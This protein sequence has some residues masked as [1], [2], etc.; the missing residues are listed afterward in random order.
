MGRVA[1]TGIG[2]ICA[3]GR[4]VSEF[5]RALREGRPAIAPIEGP[6]ISRLRF[7]NGAQLRGYS[8]SPHFGDR[9]ADFLDRFAQFAV[10]AARE[11]AADAN[12][13]WT[14]E[15]KADSAVVTGT[16]VGGQNTQDLAFQA[17]YAQRTG[18]VNPLSIPKV[19][20]NAGASQISMDFGITG[21][22]YTFSTACS[23]AGHAIGHAF[24]MIKH[25]EVSMAITGGSEAPFSWGILKGWEA[26]RVVST[27]TCRPFSKGRTG[28]ILGEGAAMFVLEP[29][30]A[31]RARGARI[32]AEIT[33]FG[34]SSDATHITCP[35]P[36]GASRAMHAALREA[37]V[38]PE[39][40]GYINAH[41][42]GTIANDVCEAT[43]IRAV[44]GE[45]ASRIAVSSTKSLHGHALGAAAALEAA[46]TILALRDGQLPPT[47]NFL[48]P[49]PDCDLD[50]IANEARALQVE[51]AIS[52]SFAFGGM[53]AVL[54]FRTAL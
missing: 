7:T 22:S 51:H 1:V 37:G 38:M 17:L 49:D 45:H 23:S 18:R 14:P 16:C 34:M 26:M 13:E 33:G 31:A 11:A 36:E 52:N 53:N 21:P 46:A 30:E 50:V 40:V 15:L 41:G 39:R 35:S 44:F 47:A 54:A 2:V 27:H 19:M 10:V 3:L 32:H 48:G 5:S 25:G 9:E 28:M 42:T 6:D 24:R 43:A 4:N 20:A 29:L 12:V 8:H